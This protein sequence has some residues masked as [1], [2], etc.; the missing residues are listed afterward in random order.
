MVP[1]KV[2]PVLEPAQ[3]TDRQL[4]VDWVKKYEL[5]TPKLSST[6]AWQRG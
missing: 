1:C 4:V 3:S 6:S 5:S 2:R